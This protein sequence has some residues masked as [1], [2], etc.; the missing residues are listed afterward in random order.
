M[1]VGGVAPKNI[2]VRV[3]AATNRDL[4]EM[5]NRGEFRLDLY[6]RLNVV[7]LFVPPLRERKED[8][9][10]LLHYFLDKYNRKYKL[11]K[12]FGDIAL[13]R[14]LDYSWPG[15]VRELE[16]MVERFVVT[17]D[18]DMIAR[19]A[20]ETVGARRSFEEIQFRQNYKD[21]VNEYETVLLSKALDQY[22]TTRKMSAALG[23][24]QSTIVKKMSRL[25]VNARKKS[26]I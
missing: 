16:N 8:V 1:R 23:L 24:N 21:I 7:P 14:I 11:S 6:Y 4:S 26:S 2:D 10:A 12:S 20:A 25:G 22:G 19:P 13:N 5:V 17:G 9:P 3:I 15:N 18:S